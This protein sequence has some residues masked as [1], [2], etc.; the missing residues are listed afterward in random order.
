MNPDQLLKAEGDE[1]SK[2]LGEV[3]EVN[4]HHEYPRVGDYMDAEC[5]LCGC[6]DNEWPAEQPCL[7]AKK[8]DPIPLTPAEAFKWRDFAVE[9]YEEDVYLVSLFTVWDATVYYEY[10]DYET[11]WLQFRTTQKTI[12]SMDIDYD[13]EIKFYKWCATEAQSKHYLQAAALCVLKGKV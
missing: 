1:L 2:L 8:F 11:E 3:L 6:W 10:E 7:K 5:E 12:D 9:K 13:M 4:G